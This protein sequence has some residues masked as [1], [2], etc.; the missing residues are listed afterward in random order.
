LRNGIKLYEWH[1]RILHAKTA[2][3]D[4]EWSTIGS[5]NLD[6]LSSFRNLE[7]NASVLGERIGHEMEDQFAFDRAKS[8][9][10]VAEDWARRPMAQRLLQ[11][12][13]GHFRGLFSRN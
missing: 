8:R 6:N 1:E 10:I 7:V 4:G 9:P 2:V 12:F 13:F 5:S 11:W 3:I